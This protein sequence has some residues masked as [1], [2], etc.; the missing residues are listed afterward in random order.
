MPPRSGS[1]Q[2]ILFAIFPDNLRNLTHLHFLP[3]TNNIY[4]AKKLVV[5]VNKAD[6]TGCSSKPEVLL[7]LYHLMDGQSNIFRR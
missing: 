4:V 2:V 1:T 5:V 6:Y 7:S 3:N